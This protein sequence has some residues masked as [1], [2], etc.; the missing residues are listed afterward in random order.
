MNAV[1]AIATGLT[2]L[3]VAVAKFTEGAWITLALVPAIIVLMVAIH[4]HYDRVAREICSPEPLDLKNLRPPMVVVPIES[5]NKV[6]Q[7]ALRFAM[8]LSENVQAIYVDSGEKTEDF[9]HHWE[10]WVAAPA[11]E[12]GRQAPELVVVKSPYRL[13]VGPILNY[14]LRL[15]REHRDRQIAVV[16]SELVERH[17]FHFLLHNQRAQ[18]LTALLTLDG[19][20]RV[21]VINVPW[22]F[23]HPKHHRNG[24]T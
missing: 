21:A 18:V 17:W 9:Q 13:V 24:S 14:L 12:S 16:L 19:D 22:Y 8:T 15:E 20:E 6:A 1:G 7:K 5:W 10:S 23:E 4:H 11:R 2:T 3:V